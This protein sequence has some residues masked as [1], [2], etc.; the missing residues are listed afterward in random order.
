MS[1]AGTRIF[2]DTLSLI[3]PTM[4]TIGKAHALDMMFYFCQMSLDYSS[5]R[6]NFSEAI[7]T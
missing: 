6:P 1:T 7:Q 4:N 3:R 2:G 5:V